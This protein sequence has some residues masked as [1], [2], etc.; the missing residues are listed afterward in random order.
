MKAALINALWHAASLPEAWRFH[1]ATARV[2]ETQTRLLNT[3]LIANQNT[4]YGRRHQFESIRS[5]ND[6]QRHVPLTTY[7]DYSNLIDCIARGQPN[8]LTAQ[9]VQMF[10][11]SSGST[12]ASKLVPYPATLK[13]E[14]Q[15]GLAPWIVDLYSHYPQLRGGPAYWSVTPLTEGRRTTPGGLPIGFEEDS[16]YLGPLG[17]LIESALAVPNAIKHIGDI[18][19][20]RYIALLFL[21][22]QSNLRLISIWNPTYL[23]LLI[24]FLPEWWNDLLTDIAAGTL[25]PPQPLDLAVRRRLQLAL[26]PDPNR[27]RV[28]ATLSP[29]DYSAIW[30]HLSLISCWADGPAAGYARALQQ[31]F[32]NVSLQPKGLLATEA[33]VSFPLV[34]KEGSVLAITSHFF[35]FLP[36]ETFQRSISTNALL[37]HQLEKGQTYAVVVTTSGGLYRY[38]L[39]DVIEVVEFVGQAPCIRFVGKQDH[40]SDWFGEKLSEPFVA[41]ALAQLFNQHQLSPTFAMLAP[42]D[43]ERDFCYTLY[44]ELPPDQ[45]LNN[46]HCDLDAAL[47]ANFHYAYCRQLGQLAEPRLILVVNGVEAYLQACQSR[48]QKLGNIKPAALQKTTGWSQWFQPLQASNG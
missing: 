42:D 27:A 14:F 34:G 35:E 33:F 23:T 40:V 32:P 44:L 1:Q 38:Q 5:V 45:H 9:P 12:A 10:E 47:S 24:K 7:D 21:L 3:Y 36:T 11:P 29:D 22:R 25:S 18:K 13:A 46:L 39:Q 41:G 8:V 43:S 20:F 48:G 26:T 16:A 6:Y 2:A 31:S 19:A 4:A 30:P 28:L 17:A 15:R 37:A